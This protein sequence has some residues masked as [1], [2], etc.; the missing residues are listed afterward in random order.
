MPE[1][2]FGN[3]IAQNVI[4]GVEGLAGLIAQ[5]FQAAAQRKHDKEMA[6]LQ[7]KN[8][9][10]L[11]K[12]MFDYQN[13]FN[14]WS[15]NKSQMVEAGVNPALMY[16]SAQPVTLGASGS[17]EA[18]AGKLPQGNPLAGISK[19]LD[20]FEVVNSRL[21]DEQNNIARMNAQTQQNV[22][23]SEVTKNNAEAARAAADTAGKIG[24]NKLRRRLDNII[25]DQSIA[26]L[27][28]TSEETNN[29]RSMYE[30][31]D[32]LLSGRVEQLS[33]QNQRLLLDIEREPL[34][35]A[36]LS[37]NIKYLRSLESSAYADAALTLNQ[38]IT[39]NTRRA[40]LVKEGKA[41]DEALRH[42]QLDRIMRQCGLAKRHTVE[43]KN[44]TMADLDTNQYRQAYAL[45][46]E[47]GFS[48]SDAVSACLWY[49]GV[50]PAD[51]TPEIIRTAGN[52]LTAGVGAAVGASAMSRGTASAKAIKAAASSAPS[53]L[54]RVDR[55]R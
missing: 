19:S 16:G 42:S 27:I 25:V 1:K 33:Y 12:E 17:A 31:R 35:R 21:A 46:V 41:I 9:L 47:A 51:L 37:Q 2:Y 29:I 3:M 8:T 34:V 45:L 20:P 48:D 7:Y 4:G 30:E 22:G 54:G 32:A 39:E 26:N 18:S 36:E 43:G 49:S 13:S 55:H 24:D 53:R 44:A 52:V 15:N 14:S 23:A 10:K 5:P 6:E 40:N 38:N 11:Q 50:N 28:K